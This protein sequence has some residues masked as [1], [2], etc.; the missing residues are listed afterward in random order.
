M[1]LWSKARCQ[2]Y[3]SG[4]CVKKNSR[5]HILIGSYTYCDRDWDYQDPLNI[6]GCWI[7][8]TTTMSLSLY[9]SF[10]FFAYFV[11]II[12]LAE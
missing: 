9:F 2:L 5:F 1:G 10:I 11:L 4:A 7:K 3:F 8:R 12:H 6:I